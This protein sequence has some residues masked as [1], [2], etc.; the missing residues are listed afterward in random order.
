MREVNRIEVMPGDVLILTHPLGAGILRVAAERGRLTR[1][2]FAAAMR[3]QS[4]VA[5]AS[6]ESAMRRN[7]VRAAIQIGEAGLAGAALE[8]AA[9]GGITLIF[10]ESDLP[11]FPEVLDFVR[12]GIAASGGE[13]N[14]ARFAPQVRIAEEVGDEMAVVFFDPQEAGGMLIAA[15]ADEAVPL[16]A[17]L[18]NSGYH[19]AT[20]MGRIAARGKFAIELV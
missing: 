17:E 3:E 20:I 2:A 11:L 5:G 10:E 4:P 15:A 7:G 18:Q 14:R 16:L 8:M 6:A 1:D 19:D 12:E 13:R 9:S